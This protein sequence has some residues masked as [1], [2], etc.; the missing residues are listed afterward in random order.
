MTASLEQRVKRIV[1]MYEQISDDFFHASMERI[2]PYIKRSAKEEAVT[3]YGRG[4]L[5][6]VAEILLTEYYD[7]VYKKPKRADVSICNDDEAKTLEI[8]KNLQ[9]E[10]HANQL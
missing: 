8:L 6:R 10:Y 9:K 2:S 1:R 4:D 5:E 7:V 3:A